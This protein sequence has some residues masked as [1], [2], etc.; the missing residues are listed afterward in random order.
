MTKKI[1]ATDDGGVTDLRLRYEIV[2]DTN[3]DKNDLEGHSLRLTRT[4]PA[5]TLFDESGILVPGWARDEVMFDGAEVSDALPW[6]IPKREL[7]HG[8][9]VPGLGPTVLALMTRTPAASLA[10]EAGSD[11]PQTMTV[12]VRFEGPMARSRL[13]RPTVARGIVSSTEC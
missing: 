6:S 13:V 11:Y 4:I 8:E 10:K 1:L 9:L 2:R 5:P 12:T 3:D 7:K